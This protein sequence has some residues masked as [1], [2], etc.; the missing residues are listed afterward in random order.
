MVGVFE[1]EMAGQ[2]VGQPAHFAP[3]HGVGLSGDRHRP[4]A[5]GAD[6]ACGE[7]AIENGIDLVRARG[8]LVDALAEDGD[9][10]PGTNPHVAERGHIFGV[11]AGCAQIVGLGALHC[12]IEPVGVLQEVLIDSATHH[13]L[14]QQMIEQRHIA[15]DGQRE[16]QIGAVAA[17]RAAWVDHDDL[18]AALGFR[19]KHALVQDRVAPGEVGAHQHHQIRLVE[20]FI[21]ARHRICAKRAFMAS[22]GGGHAKARVGID[23]GGADEAFDE[24]VGDVIVLCQKLTGDIE[25]DG[26]WAVLFCGLLEAVSDQLQRVIPLGFTSMDQRRAETVAK[27]DRLAQS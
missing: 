12:G 18:G 26:V 20:I 14:G 10:L 1:I 11:K 13:D 24:L 5:G 9:D 27:T 17:C 15:A 4:A 22:N 7:V 21:G 2:H 25:G 6:A 3:A 16:M 23:I 8:G 19:G